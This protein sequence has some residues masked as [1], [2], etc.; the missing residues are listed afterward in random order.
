M[1]TA[2]SIPDQ[3]FQTGET[4][5]KHLGLSRSELYTQALRAFIA[6][7]DRQHI[8]DALN[9][10]YEQ[11]QSELDPVVAQMQ[12]TSLPREDW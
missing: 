2:I 4:L 7:H 9:Q 1:K 3:V 10:V 8:T 12:F 6:A 5:A 11:E